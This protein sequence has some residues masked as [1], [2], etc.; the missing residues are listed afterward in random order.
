VLILL[1]CLPIFI[2]VPFLLYK[3]DIDV[4][5]RHLRTY[6]TLLKTIYTLL[7]DTIS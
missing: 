6:L 5:E 4:I 1:F 7:G 2:N 3:L